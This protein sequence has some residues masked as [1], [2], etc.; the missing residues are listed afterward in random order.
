MKNFTLTFL[1]L[2]LTYLIQAQI[3]LNHWEYSLNPNDTFQLQLVNN[4]SNSF[5]TE[6]VNQT[7]DYSAATLGSIINISFTPTDISTQMNI[8]NAN[9]QRIWFQ[10]DFLGNSVDTMI[11]AT[12]DRGFFVE[13]IKEPGFAQNIAS[14]TGGSSDSLIK[15]ASTEAWTSPLPW[16]ECPLDYA[17][18][19]TVVATRTSTYFLS[20]ASQNLANYEIERRRT[21]THSYS[22]IGWGDLILTNPTTMMPDT[23]EVL[24]QRRHRIPVDSFYDA[25]GALVSSSILNLFNLT[26]GSINDGWTYYEF[27]TRGPNASSLTFESPYGNLSPSSIYSSGDL[28]EEGF[29][30]STISPTFIEVPHRIFP[31]PVT[32][33]QFQL[34]ID[35]T[36]AENWSISIHNVTGQLIQQE[37]ISSNTSQIELN[38]NMPNG[39]YIYSIND[40]KGKFVATGKLNLV[41]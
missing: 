17:D 41:D 29:N 32:N 20:V 38:N 39:T 22:V 40:E 30:V 35:K 10:R 9:T 31:N 1:F 34:E 4:A 33:H 36:S 3:T 28:F 11:F 18:T 24:L 27:Y 6:G 23:F 25:S 21:M 37:T 15:M 5:P 7:W 26:Q 8:P 13:G 12:D 16:V 2:S 19:S 14:F